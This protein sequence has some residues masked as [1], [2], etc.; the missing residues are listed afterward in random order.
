[1]K[2]IYYNGIF[3]VQNGMDVRA[4]G[5]EKGRIEAIGEREEVER[6]AEGE[7][8]ERHDMKGCFI[9][10]GFNDSHLHLL[11]YGY[12]LRGADLS[13]CTSSLSAV[14]QR[15]L[16]YKKE[17]KGGKKDWIVGRGWNHDF[18]QDE[19]R[20]PDRHDLDRVSKERPVMIY[21]ACGHIA[22]V[23]SAAL[24]AAG[25]TGKTVQPAG[26]CFDVDES[27]EPTGVLRENGIEMVSRIIPGP[28]KEEIKASIVESMKRLNARGITSAQSDDL[29]AFPGISYETVLRA[30]Q[31]LEREGLM[32]VKVNEQCL[33]PT[34]DDMKD[35]FS[36][37]YRTGFGSRYF[38]IGPL[39]II[40]D[41]SLGARTACLSRPYEDDPE[42]PENCGIPVYSQAELDRRIGYASEQGMQVAVHAI[43]DRA[44]DMVIKAMERA[45][46]GLGENKL[47]HGIV[48]C[49]ITTKELLE[50]FKELNLHAYIQSIFLNYD[51]RIA[52]SRLGKERALY[53]YQ[54]KTLMDMGLSVSNGSDAPVERPDVLAGIQCAV[55]RTTLDGTKT[56]LPR[57]ALSVEE[58]LDTY[59]AMGARASFEEEE[60]GKLLPGM[61]ADFTVLSQDIR[62]CVPD[63]IQK[64]TVC[65]TFVDGV[66]V[67][68]QADEL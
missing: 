32:T 47:R 13:L 59:T 10:P 52:E 5:V 36:R 35:F 31:E 65:K 43:G 58:A 57:Q 14:I 16:E 42:N 48:H 1:M 39:K 28:E 20:F 30:Y 68:G 60:K 63:R 34:M 12:G 55:T 53:T 24:L 23:N 26:G 19:K 61:A 11:E 18:F 15:L 46:T 6:W 17:H 8:A 7:P 37:G 54:F 44:M 29:A 50:K 66:C 22:S 41:G 38:K 9:V 56:F 27:G 33:F 40:S 67:F 64:V 45:G 51:N 21:R 49:Q 25:I 4:M 2:H 62:K 3:Y